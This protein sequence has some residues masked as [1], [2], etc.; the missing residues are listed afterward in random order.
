MGHLTL[1]MTGTVLLLVAA[2]SA[3]GA[4]CGEGESSI[5]RTPQDAQADSSSDDARQQDEP[6]RP[7]SAEATRSV[8]D[9]G[10]QPASTAKPF[11]FN[12]AELPEGF[13]APGPVDRIVIKTYPPH[14]LARVRSAGSRDQSG[15]FRPLFRHIQ[16]NDIAM[17]APV[18]MTYP[19]GKGT[20]GEPVKKAEQ[21]D[22]M[23]FFYREPG[24]GNPGPDPADAQ[25]TVEDVPVITVLSIGVRGSYT[26][27][28]MVRARQ[29]LEQW[30]ASYPG[31]VRPVG[32]IRFMGYNSPFVP[33]F[34]RFGEVQWPIE[35]LPSEHSAHAMR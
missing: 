21:P 25:V 9:S 29:K 26:N 8:Y 14:R 16:R 13:P 17:T 24:L 11:L 5:H 2:V 19:D 12:E 18:Q 7:D 1:S 28:R 31:R 3:L 34:L 15:M 6:T 27:E 30:M 35:V 4:G 32:P 10:D 20:E 33:G 22:S 23:A